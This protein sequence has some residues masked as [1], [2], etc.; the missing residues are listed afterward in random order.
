V[1]HNFVRVDSH[2]HDE[3][4]HITESASIRVKMNDKRLRK[5][6]LLKME[7]IEP[8][9]IGKDDFE[10]LLVGWGSLYSPIKEAVKLLNKEGKTQYSAL[11]FGDI[12]PLPESLIKEKS[13]KAKK[14]INIEQNAT[15]QLALIIRENTGIEFNNSILKYDGRP[16]SGGEIYN[17]LKEIK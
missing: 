1:S 7:L 9:F 6:E 15:G 2:E 3:Y 14:I 11:I 16:I 4:G 12:W 8:E 17:N 13:N 10:T 5:M